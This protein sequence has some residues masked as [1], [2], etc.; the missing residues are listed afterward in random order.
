MSR[1]E[2]GTDFISGHLV[3]R[4]I[5]LRIDEFEDRPDSRSLQEE[6]RSITSRKKYTGTV[7]GLYV[8]LMVL[9]LIL[10]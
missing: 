7:P 3:L 9:C 4:F 10:T 5:F 1:E 8:V 6:I 2:T